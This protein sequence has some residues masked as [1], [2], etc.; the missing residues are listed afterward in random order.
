VRDDV[1]GEKEILSRNW[2]SKPSLKRFTQMAQSREGLGN[3]ARHAS[4]KY[5]PPAKALSLRE[6]KAANS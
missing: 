6:A 1:N 4:K 5:K 2:I 3:D